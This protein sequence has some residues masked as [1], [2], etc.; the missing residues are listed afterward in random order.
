[1]YYS[2]PGYPLPSSSCRVLSV[3]DDYIYVSVFAGSLITVNVVKVFVEQSGYWSNAVPS[4]DPT[5][6]VYAQIINRLEGV[7]RTVIES[8]E[9][10]EAYAVGERGG[11]DVEFGDP[12]Y[13]NNAKFYA[14][15]AKQAASESGYMFFTNKN[16]RLYFNRTDNVNVDFTLEE[17]RLVYYGD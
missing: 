5:P 9:T 2:H 14:E 3:P 6:S 8:A 16:G 13:D 4:V 15:K 12:T 11:I 1:M 17:G 7:E 10:A